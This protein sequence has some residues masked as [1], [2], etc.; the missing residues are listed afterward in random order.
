MRA[1]RSSMRIRFRSGCTQFAPIGS[2]I[3]GMGGLLIAVLRYGALPRVLA[4]LRGRLQPPGGVWYE[5][6]PRSLLLRFWRF[7]ARL[8][9]HRQVHLRH[10]PLERL[11]C[12]PDAGLAGGVNR[13]RSEEHT[14]ELQS[15]FGISYA[16]FC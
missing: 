7:P 1:Y 8:G 15:R 10:P 13:L 4:G 9:P 16:V 14:S 3:G 12:L 2:V 11:P 6:R 5:E